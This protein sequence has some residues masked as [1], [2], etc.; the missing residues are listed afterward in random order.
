MEFDSIGSEEVVRQAQGSK[1]APREQAL[2]RKIV[3]CEQRCRPRA[4]AITELKRQQSCVP[5]VAVNDVGA[6]AGNYLPDSDFGSYSGQMCKPLSI[7]APITTVEVV[8]KAAFPSEEGRAVYQPYRKA[9]VRQAGRDY[10][11]E[12]GVRQVVQFGLGPLLGRDTQG[13]RVAREAETDIHAERCEGLWQC[14]TDICQPAGLG[15][16]I[17]LRRGNRAFT[18]CSKGFDQNLENRLYPISSMGMRKLDDH[19]T[20]VFKRAATHWVGSD[21]SSKTALSWKPHKPT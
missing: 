7:V 13:G 1:R 11:R 14:R 12:G 18:S 3:N 4:A 20:H 9:A 21:V 6:P 5:I 19:G 8:I 17:N 10:L 2:E 15:E 16:G